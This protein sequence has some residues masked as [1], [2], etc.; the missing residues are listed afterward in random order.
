MDYIPTVQTSPPAA[1]VA[2]S[3]ELKTDVTGKPPPKRGPQI[4]K[5][6]KPYEEDGEKKNKILEFKVPYPP[7]PNC[8]YCYGRGYI[9]F[10]A[11]TEEI[12]PCR[13]CYPLK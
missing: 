7:K 11:D 12:V 6:V 4:L 5:A 2:P 3:Y 13:K 8:K 1:P 9:G 10:E